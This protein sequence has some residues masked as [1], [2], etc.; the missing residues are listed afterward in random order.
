[1]ALASLAP[2]A[3][4]TLAD[5]A[6][7]AGVSAATASRVLSGSAHV[8]PKTRV[9]VEQ[10]VAR[11]GYV[12]NRAPR[13]VRSQQAGSIALVVGEENVKV[14][15]DPFFARILLSFGRELAEV[16]LQLVLL[17]L[18]TPRD[19]RMVARYLRSGHV[20]GAFFV[21]M[22][23]G[24]GFDL[25][26]LGIPVVLCGRPLSG[27]DGVCYVD[28]DNTGGAKKAV[29]YLLASGRTSVATIA[30]PPDMAPGIDRLLGYRKAMTAAG[31]HDPGMIA[32]GDYTRRAG[33]HALRRLIDHRP[34]LD[35]V[36]VA[37][38]LMAVG[39]LDALD[40]LGRRVPEDVAVLGFD[41]LPLSQYTK[42]RL[43]TVR[44]PVDAMAA[45]MVREM[46]ALVD[47]PGRGPTRTVLETE[48]VL[49]DSA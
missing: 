24:P 48:L 18:H 37:S 35:A 14:F 33:E 43:S 2:G 23:L 17:T 15:A 36:F 29:N 21:S 8:Q 28:A 3:P 32:Y 31:I 34:R 22:H 30:G 4:P 27:G 38:D 16:D 7:L 1:M 42:P 41:D 10:A 26:G 6:R 39:A 25:A 47:D 40:R 19:Y 46:L 11:L 45:Q 13:A 5:V 9:K 20:D 49:R 12:R 44:Q